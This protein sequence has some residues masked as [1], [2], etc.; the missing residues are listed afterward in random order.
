M[1]F[2]KRK[3]YQFL[4]K[5]LKRYSKNDLSYLK[6]YYYL[7]NEKTLNIDNPMDF[8]EKLNWLKL[9]KYREDYKDYVDKYAVREIV[10]KSIGEK[11]LNDLIAVYDNVDD[12]D[13]NALP[14][15]FVLKGTHGSGYNIIVRDKANLDIDQTKK[16]LNK[17]LSD[18][19][20]Y[21]YREYIYKDV[22]PRIIAEKYLGQFDF[23]HI[24]DYKFLCF[25]GEPK[26]ILVKTQDQGTEK[27]CFYTMDWEKVI[28][29]NPTQSYLAKDIPKPDNFD[30]MVEVATKLSQ[31]F[32]YVRVDLYSIEKQVY[33]GELTFFNTGGMKRINIE[34][35]NKQLGDLIKL[36]SY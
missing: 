35:L 8:T 31:G 27:K 15:K 2:L 24:I 6:P 9:Y 23:G 36:P 28:D 30:E 7:K 20:F 13:F 22:K 32:I 25:Q 34:K 26:L 10:E 4:V 33:F 21:K 12:I 5:R 17:F 18:N 14:D 19:Y 11:Y 29:D 3:Y 16:E 1:N